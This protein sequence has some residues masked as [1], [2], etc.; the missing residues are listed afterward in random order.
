V[1]FLFG[2][3]AGLAFWAVVDRILTS[4]KTPPA[5]LII[6]RGMNGET[7]IV[8]V[9]GSEQWPAHTGPPLRAYSVLEDGRI[10][11]SDGEVVDPNVPKTHVPAMR[12][13]E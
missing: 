10:E 5:P 13:L 7:K 2:A 9:T 8:Q 12:I 4:H 6:E 11:Y 1:D 3:I